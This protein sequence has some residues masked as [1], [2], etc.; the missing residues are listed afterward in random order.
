MNN[1]N[2][3]VE[4][5]NVEA[6][7]NQ[8]AES[9]NPT[10]GT[11][12]GSKPGDPASKQVLVRA[13]EKD[14]QRWKDAAEKEGVSMSEFVRDCCNAAAAAT[15]DCQHDTNMCR[16]YPWGWECLKCGHKVMTEK[17]KTYNRSNTK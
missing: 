1:D 6:A 15:L 9:I 5:D 12:T 11:N 16:F 14:H 7:M 10:R 13:S 4:V 2:E 3:N 17:A 8:V